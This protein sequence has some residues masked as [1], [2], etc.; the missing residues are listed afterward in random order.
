MSDTK[1]FSPQILFD[2]NKKITKLTTCDLNITADIRNGNLDICFATQSL[3]NA[4]HEET[5]FE[6]SFQTSLNSN[7]EEWTNILISLSKIK[8]W[9]MYKYLMVNVRIPIH[10][11]NYQLRFKI[12]S[13]LPSNITNFL[14][15]HKKEITSAIDFINAKNLPIK[16]ENETNDNHNDAK[17]QITHEN[18]N[19]FRMYGIWSE[20]KQVNIPSSLVDIEYR[21]GD[22]VE[23]TPNGQALLKYG[24]ITDI[25]IDNISQAST[26]IESNV[27][28]KQT[29]I[30]IMECRKM[31]KIEEYT[32]EK[33]E[34]Y[35]E[36]NRV[37]YPSSDDYIDLADRHE[38]DQRLIVRYV[39]FITQ[40][41][42]RT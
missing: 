11:F 40:Y 22:L 12:R 5:P 41:T 29:D 16:E 42:F 27:N 8:C 17:N 24:T 31:I 1:T 15:E 19:I 10:V 37:F 7:T 3:L 9:K 33:N 34:V 18:E 4:L 36:Y 6:I 14:E 20:V 21:I 32:E 26:K 28:A 38:V 13:I 39:A 25:I 23:Y 2:F 30:K 35:V